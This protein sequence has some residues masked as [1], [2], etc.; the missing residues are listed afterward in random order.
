MS[1]TASARPTVWRLHVRPSGGHG[2]VRR[3]YAF[4]LAESVVGMGWAVAPGSAATAADYLDACV[5]THGRGQDE[6]VRRLMSMKEG[7][8]VWMRSPRGVYHL[9]R[10]TGPWAYRGTPEHRDADIVN[11]RPATILAVGTEDRV[12]GKVVAN[13]RGQRTLQRVLDNTAVSYSLALWDR[14]NGLD[15]AAGSAERDPFSLFSDGDVEDLL[16]VYLQTQGWLVCPARRRHDTLAYEYVLRHRDDGREAVLQVKTGGTPVDLGSLPDEVGVA[17]AF[18]PNGLIRGA[19]SRAE[20]IS[21]ADVLAFARRRPD[22][23]PGTVQAW[24][25]AV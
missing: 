22:L 15:P 19:N 12:P 2:D 4:C 24:L 9:A 25:G 3:S 16:Y 6:N 20:V 11:L 13:F 7:D 18:Q 21:R 1:E 17:F 5:A 10:I 14:L 23:L 8:L